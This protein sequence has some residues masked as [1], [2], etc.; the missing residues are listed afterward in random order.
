MNVLPLNQSSDALQ[1]DFGIVLSHESSDILQ[2]LKKIN[3]SYFFS[4]DQELV[5]KLKV[6]NPV[7]LTN[8]LNSFFMEMVKEDNRRQLSA[9]V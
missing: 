4:P 8:I 1:H 9:K 6:I 3:T 5:N 2:R 7:E